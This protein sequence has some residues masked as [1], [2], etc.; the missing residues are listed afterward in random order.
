MDR[1]LLGPREDFTVLATVF[2][3]E[4]LCSPEGCWPFLLN[5]LAPP[6]G[7]WDIQYSND[8]H[9][10][11]GTLLSQSFKFAQLKLKKLLYSNRHSPT[12]AWALQ[13][14]AIYS[15]LVRD[16]NTFAGQNVLIHDSLTEPT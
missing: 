12:N 14:C 8:I 7:F 11:V 9:N 15:T 10:M 1:I 6:L 16:R 13:H 5:M 4:V 3:N 2:E